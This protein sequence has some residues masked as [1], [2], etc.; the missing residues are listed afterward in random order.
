[1]GA[2]DKIS[3]QEY[4]AIKAVS[5]GMLNCLLT[6]SPLH[7]W[8][9]SPFNPQRAREDSSVMDLGSYAHACLLEGDCQNLV[10]IEADDWRTKDA[11]TARDTARASGK[12]P[13]L[14]HKV[15]E[16]QR[17]VN[18][19]LEYVAHSEIA[20]VFDTGAAEETILFEQIDVP[21]KARPDWLTADRSICLS[22]KTTAGS[23]NP[24]AWIRAQL[25]QYDLAA[26]FYESAVLSIE[27]DVDVQVVHLVQEQCEPY[28]CSLV[29]LAPAFHEL[30]CRKL[31]MALKAW[32]DCARRNRWPAYPA[33]IAWAEPKPWQIADADER[34]YRMLGE[35]DAVQMEKGLQ[36]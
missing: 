14:K 7:A 36:V 25:P 16:V 10:V 21:C 12:L 13:I 20:G 34:E 3:M 23:A 15:A 11:R 26:A 30:A 1:M 29:A 24:D 18:A 17:M 22:Y 31:D 6:Q 9:D 2:P 19:A 27:P 8:F 5:S 33:R 35:V 4:L 28:S 32:R